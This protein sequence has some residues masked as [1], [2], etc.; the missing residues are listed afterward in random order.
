[1]HIVKRDN[2]ALC[3]VDCFHI[4]D[5]AFTSFQRTIKEAIHFETENPLN[6]QLHHVNVKLSL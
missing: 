2:F 6:Q 3:S 5:H 4:L 1:M